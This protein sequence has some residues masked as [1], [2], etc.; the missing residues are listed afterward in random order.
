MICKPD[1]A[2]QA[3]AICRLGTT[4]EDLAEAAVPG[5]KRIDARVERVR[6]S[7]PARLTHKISVDSRSPV[8]GEAGLVRLWQF[9]LKRLRDRAEALFVKLAGARFPSQFTP[10]WW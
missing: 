2:E 6:G 4:D 5:R 10:I 7:A 8:G 9:S 1:F 3:C